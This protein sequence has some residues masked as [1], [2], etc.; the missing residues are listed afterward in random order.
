MKVD[1]RRVAGFL[2]ALGLVGPGSTAALAA[3]EFGLKEEPP[4][5][6][7]MVCEPAPS[8]SP[9][10]PQPPSAEAGRLADAATQAMILGDLDGALEFLNRALRADSTAAE[11][12]YLR[13]RILLDRGEVDSA[14]ADL[15][16]YLRYEPDGESAPETRERLEQAAEQGAAEHLYHAFEEGV[17]LYSAG[18]LEESEAAFDLVVSARPAAATAVYNRGIVRARLDLQGPARADLQRY[19]ELAPQAEDADRVRRYVMSLA[20]YTGPAAG[21]AFVTGAL[22]PG[23]GQFYTG[24]PLF[25]TLVMG[26]AAGTLA[27]GYFYERTTIQ[28]R[29]ADPQGPCP[30]DQ[31]ADEAT[32]RPYF[33]LAVGAAAGIA[34]IAAVEAAV[35]ASRLRRDR[36]AAPSA[37][38][39]AAERVG[40]DRTGAV[41]LDLI[42]LRF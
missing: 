38:A 40:I 9:D 6:R 34:L 39:A 16:R 12:L 37:G 25:G 4:P 10:V 30:P 2:C 22:I 7:S 41:R 24:R 13:S 18:N 31:V 29:V 5:A 15:C 17:R 32:E 20:T 27:G 23:A 36:F 3:Q 1:R 35:H 19:L 11:A 26:V 14:T 28:C 33:T 42:R 21:R 8:G